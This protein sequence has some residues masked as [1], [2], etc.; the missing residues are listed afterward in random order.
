MK[1]IIAIVV[2]AFVFGFISSEAKADPYTHEGFQF[3]GT[4]GVGYLNNT[5]PVS[6]SSIYGE[7]GEADVYFGGALF[8]G[9]FLG[10]TASD[11]T[12]NQASFSQ[13]DVSLYTPYNLRMNLFTF[14]PYVDWYPSPRGGFHILGS[15]GPSNLTLSAVSNVSATGGYVSGGVGYDWWISRQCT[16]GVLGK[17]TYSSETY[18]DNNGSFAENTSGGAVLFSVSYH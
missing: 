7:A 9:F 2:C 18:T 16:L 14:G 6:N 3:R 5:E 17:L 4:V 8:P 12:V 13:N 1:K 15:F 10:G 11:I